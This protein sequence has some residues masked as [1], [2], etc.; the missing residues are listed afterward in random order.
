[1]ARS[2]PKKRSRK[3]GTANAPRAV[4]SQRREQRAERTV[5]EQTRRHTA[6]RT[7][8]TVGERPPNPFGGFP[9]SEIMIAA[10][11]VGVIVWLFERLQPILITSVVV[12][13]VGVLEFTIREHFSGYRSHTTLLAML[14]A[15]LAG[16][17]AVRLAG[18]T[19]GDAPLIVLAIP[20]FALLF[21]P[22]RK[23]FQIARHARAIRP[24]T[25]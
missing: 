8:G 7:L 10:G 2:T 15:V 13:A 23:R 14:P 16:V 22:L 9:V 21:F 5:A 4:P 20:V 12:M 6:H 17:G 19:S 24:P 1:V 18:E 3:R 25:P 11:I